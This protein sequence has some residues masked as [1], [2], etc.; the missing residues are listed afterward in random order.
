[1]YKT[2][3]KITSL[4]LPRT[5]QAHFTFSVG[6]PVLFVL[7]NHGK[8]RTG[9]VKTTT[10]IPWTHATKRESSV[11]ILS[12]SGFVLIHHLSQ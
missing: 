9:P 11:N 8:K 3:G 6:I 12:V 2:L 1:M 4:Q 7:T 10:E 5:F